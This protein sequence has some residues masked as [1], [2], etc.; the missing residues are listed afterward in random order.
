MQKIQLCQQSKFGWNW[1]SQYVAFQGQILQIGQ[2]SNFSRNWAA[3]IIVV[4]LQIRQFCHPSK[5]GRQGGIQIVKKNWKSILSRLQHW[6]WS[7]NQPGTAHTDRNYS[8]GVYSL[9]DGFRIL[10][11]GRGGG[12]EKLVGCWVCCILGRSSIH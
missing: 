3:Q 9:A 2:Q 12:E 11:R 1:A 4:Q 6:S 10:L 5:F 8:V 7:W